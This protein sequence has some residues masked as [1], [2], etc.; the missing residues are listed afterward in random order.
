MVVNGASLLPASEHDGEGLQHLRVVVGLEDA[1]VPACAGIE[2]VDEI[3]SEDVRVTGHQ[4]ALRLR[5]IGVEDR[6]DGIGVGGL[7]AGVLLKAV[8]DGV[9]GADGVIDLDDDQIF[10]VAVLKRLLAL[11]GAAA[12]VK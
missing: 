3:G 2:L 11:V 9:V 7:Q 1:R 5:R 10:A 12:A 8:P 4:R 6:I